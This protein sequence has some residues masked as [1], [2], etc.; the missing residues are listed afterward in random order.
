MSQSVSSGLNLQASSFQAKPA[1]GARTPGGV[2]A[3]KWYI[4]DATDQVVGRLA[5]ILARVIMGKHKPTF[6]KHTDT[7]DFVVVINS[8][9]VALTRKKW[10][11]K[12]YYNYSGYI[13]GLRKRTARE[14]RDHSPTELLKRA[15][16][17]MT[18]KSS[19]ARYQLK[20]LKLYV[21][22]QHP[23][24]AQK[25]EVL[26]ASVIRRTVLGPK[27]VSRKGSSVTAKSENTNKES[28]KK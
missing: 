23:H 20:K 14:M 3:P 27:K 7:G 1:R 10:D 24:E 18:T 21:G 6:T 5:T 26:P 8:E 28:T 16:W 11:Q 13:S 9:K 17:G 4:V 22:D 25:P 19:L 15:V 2:H 12:M